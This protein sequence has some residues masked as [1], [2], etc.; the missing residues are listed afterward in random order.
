MIKGAQCSL[1][2]SI[3]TQYFNVNEVIIQTQT[4]LDFLYLNKQ[5]VLRR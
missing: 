1:G 2:E 5:A 3:Q 4:F